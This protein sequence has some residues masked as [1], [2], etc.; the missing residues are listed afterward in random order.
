MLEYLDTAN[1]LRDEI[2]NELN[3]ILE[4]DLLCSICNEIIVK[5]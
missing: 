4:T 2:K 5:V 1:L 3:H